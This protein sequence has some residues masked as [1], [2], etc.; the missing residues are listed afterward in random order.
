M[1]LDANHF[2]L[3]S[4]AMLSGV[5]WLLAYIFIIY[6]GFKDKSYGMPIVALCGNLAWEIIF[7][8][9]LETGCP[10]TWQSCPAGLI[11]IRNFIWML[12]D[13]VIVYTV[14][15]YGRR[16]FKR[17]IVTKNFT[18]LVLG[19]IVIAFTVIYSIIPEFW[20]RNIWH[21]QVGNEIPDFLPL[22]IQGGSYYTGFALNFVMSLLFLVFIVVRENVE[23]Q[24]VYI[25][26][27][28]WLGSLAAYGF[29][30]ADGIPT[31]LVNVLYALVF[32][33]DVAYIYLVY[34]RC[35]LE[36]I[37]PWRRL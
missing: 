13:F 4:T 12:F 33:F 1:Q 34:R 5:F 10:Q 30:V 19:G 23:G 11:Q 37:N 24:S 32:L 3:L 20:V 2:W 16:Y 35:K 21:A 7:G 26:I 17:P 18:W 29:M 6:R 22:T 36:G 14:L 9:G 31:Q 15:K 27:N 8:L 25:A 28:K